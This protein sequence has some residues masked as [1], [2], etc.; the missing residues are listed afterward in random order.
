MNKM[1]IT[2]AIGIVAM[3]PTVV[4]TDSSCAD[5][6]ESK[7]ESDV[8]ERR[9]IEQVQEACTDEWMTIPGV[10]GTG[11]GLCGGKP[12]IKVYASKPAED[13][14]EKI[15]KT[16]DGYSITVEETGAFRTFE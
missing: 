8:A 7:E 11:I 13:L 12:C 16:V 5:A 6:D 4:L 10:E 15:P 1:I 3:Q 2:V 9:T 14:Q